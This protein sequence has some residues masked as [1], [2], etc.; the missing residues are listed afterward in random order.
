VRDVSGSS[1]SGAVDGLTLFS[2]GRSK[3]DTSFN[4][5][6]LVDE[7]QPEVLRSSWDWLRCEAAAHRLHRKSLTF[8]RLAYPLRYGFNDSR[9]AFSR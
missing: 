4:L 2:A 8:I 9:I 3:L 1:P 5:E 7:T 6:G